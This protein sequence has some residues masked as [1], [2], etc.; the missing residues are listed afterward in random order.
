ME[1][2]GEYNNDALYALL[3]TSAHIYMMRERVDGFSPI[4][5]EDR[6]SILP[7]ECYTYAYTYTDKNIIVIIECAKGII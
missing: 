7:M 4:N 2:E 5:Y 6:V 1:N 3:C